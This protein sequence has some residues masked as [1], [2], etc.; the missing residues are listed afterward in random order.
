MGSPRYAVAAAVLVL[1]AGC[2]GGGASEDDAAPAATG[3]EPAAPSV[4][5][6]GEDGDTCAEVRA[7]ID[8]FNEGD[9]DETV[10]RF[11]AALPLAEAAADR[12]ENRAA[13][14]LLEAV[15][16]YAELPAEDYLD[17]AASSPDFQ[18]YKA[19]TLGQCMTLADLVSPTEPPAQE[20]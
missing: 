9:Y 7:G 4:S 2:T 14:L 20:V 18:R 10:A 17:A 16:Y 13:D 8:A 11:E 5:P 15:V 1:V 6:P 12:S 3:S 19:I